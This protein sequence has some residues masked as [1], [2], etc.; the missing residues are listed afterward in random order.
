MVDALLLT[1]TSSLGCMLSKLKV[2]VDGSIGRPC[3]HFVSFTS[4]W[5][6]ELR[7]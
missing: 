6:L 5:L 2:R 1:Y 7:G 3:K 4:S